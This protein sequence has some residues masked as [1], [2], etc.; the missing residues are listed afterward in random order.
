MKRHCRAILLALLL[1]R[2]VMAQTLIMG[3]ASAPTGLDPH[4]SVGYTDA[5]IAMDLYE[6]LTRRNAAGNL[7]PALAISW[8]PFGD[9]AW[10]FT[11]RQGVRFHDGA[12]F[13]ADDAIF[14][15]ARAVSL[16]S[17]FSG[18]S[19][20]LRAVQSVERLGPHQL[21]IHTRGPAPDLPMDLSAVAI[22]PQGLGAA[23]FGEAQAIGTGPFRVTAYLHDN[24]LDMRRNQQWWDSPPARQTVSL[25]FI[26]RGTVRAAALLAGDL[27]VIEQVGPA[28]LPALAANPAIRVSSLPSMQ[29]MLLRFNY[30]PEDGGE[31][32]TDAA[33]RP[34]TTNPLR[35]RRV[36][37]A[38]SLAIHRRN[39]MEKLLPGVAMASGQLAPAGVPGHAPDLPVPDYAPDRAR[40]L[41]AQ[42][43]FPNG[44]QLTLHTPADRVPGGTAVA[45]AVAQMWTRIGITTRIASFPWVNYATRIARGDFSLAIYPCCG[46]T[47]DAGAALF[48][49]L[50]TRNPEL[51][52]GNTN[53]GSYSNPALDALLAQAMTRFDPASRNA[54]Q[55][56]AARLAAADIA[57]IPLFQQVNAWASRAPITVTPR[58]DGRSPATDVR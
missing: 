29:S 5:S 23:P 39:L 15:L 3:M 28:D 1:V 33:G 6:G 9:A 54:L 31:G 19:G 10:D 4:A 49:V 21:R 17:G 36:R 32:I 11:L 45:E 53:Y 47:A 20:R 43:G 34:L 38:L 12:L 18:L 16:P 44:F 8:T 37:E 46:S 58:L 56:D 14:S 13:T 25:R 2:P 55:Q 7:E 22:L 50:G 27:D 52:R 30:V 35:D 57:M 40:Q 51:R 24:R 48:T 42:A 41:L 26:P